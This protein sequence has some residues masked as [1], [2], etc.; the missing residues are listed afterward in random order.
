MAGRTFRG[1]LSTAD[2][3]GD[4]A[5]K[6]CH[7]EFF[8]IYGAVL[9][10]MKKI[11]FL[12]LF[13][14]LFL[15]NSLGGQQL[16]L[17][18]DSLVTDTTMHVR[19]KTVEIISQSEK[20]ITGTSLGKISFDP[21]AVKKL[22]SIL[23]N[24]DLLK[25]LELTPGVQNAGDANTN[26][27]VRGGEPGQNLLLY[28]DVSLYT[29]GHLLGF[30]PL[31]N[32]DH[33]TNL[34][35][36]K[37]GMNARTGGRLS[38][39][40]AVK[41]RQ[42]IPDKISLMGNV[43]LL[44]SQLTLEAPLSE[45]YALYLSGRKTYIELLMQPLLNATVNNNSENKV[46][47]T[48][49][50][51]WD[52]NMTFVGNLSENNKLVIDAFCS[53]DRFNIQDNDLLL[54]GE[55]SWKNQSLSA[56][57]DTRIRENKFSQQ[58]SYSNYNNQLLSSQSE[59]NLNYSSEIKD[60]GYQNSYSF[61][62]KEIPLETGLQYVFHQL[63]PQ[64]S[65]VRNA[66]MVYHTNAFPKQIAH[67]ISVFVSSSF[68][69]NSSTK[70][71][72]GL[73]YNVYSEQ[74]ENKKT[75]FSIE[76]R[77]SVSYR[78]NETTI[79]RAAYDKQNQYLNL[80]TSS[81]VGLPV[82]S[83]IAA[84]GDI[85]PQFA[86]QFSAAYYKTFKNDAYELSAEVYY[87]TMGNVMEYSR[88]FTGND[89]NDFKNNIFYGFGRAYGLELILKKNHGKLTGWLSYT[90]ARSD[91]KMNG[92]NEGKTFPAKFDRR[93]DLSL[94]GAY[95]FN[96]RWDASLVCIYATGNAYTLPS[97]WYFINNTPVKEYADYNSARMPDYSRTDISVNYWFKKDNGLNFSIYNMFMVDNPV[98]IFLNLKQDKD[99]GNLFIEVKKKRLYTIIPSISWRFKF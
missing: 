64:T 81:N 9:L 96:E 1:M 80:L 97:S 87:K 95:S 43:G 83:W 61:R 56:R 98:Y 67:D 86:N 90:L 91:R 74:K 53:Q 68:R 36:V 55:L 66:D 69:L 33:L 7:T 26:M 78:L 14:F 52:G 34:E 25:L 99:S 84:S 94:V 59:M 62:V 46:E 54:N 76:P 16:P 88:N 31:F 30:F 89:E 27:Y 17:Q 65:Q 92:I 39:V 19:G 3:K 2:Y 93:H 35:L 50:G 6:S 38:S 79:L 60:M 20:K 40:I 45:K 28:N 5:L 82:N 41:S 51:F 8:Q 23:G 57:W 42:T 63:K 73:R 13:T 18:R 21:V 11:P 85:S 49:Y 32:A 4:K 75:F 72:A 48:D 24:T 12:I 70:M 77:L 22:P 71:D 44:S 47:N 37:T 58:V 29:P 15:N 10:Y